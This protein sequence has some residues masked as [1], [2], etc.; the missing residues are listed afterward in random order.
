MNK[1]PVGLGWPNSDSILSGILHYFETKSNF[2]KAIFSFHAT[3]YTFPNYARWLGCPT[4]ILYIAYVIYIF[5]IFYTFPN[6]A[7]RL[8]CPNDDLMVRGT[9]PPAAPDHFHIK[10]NSHINDFQLFGIWLKFICEFMWWRFK[11]EMRLLEELNTKSQL[12]KILTSSICSCC[13][14]K[15]SHF[16]FL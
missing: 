11:T 6:S 13:Q 16:H 8:A 12:Q 4:Y 14:K 2:F 1:H 3:F 7:R 15:R 10:P 9:Q 5:A